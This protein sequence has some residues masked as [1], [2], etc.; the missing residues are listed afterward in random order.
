MRR[1][2]IAALG[3]FLL[4]SG[5]SDPAST[6]EGK[7][8]DATIGSVVIVDDQG[9]ETVISI[10]DADPTK[11]E[12]VLLGDVVKVTYYPVELEDG[13][14]TNEVESLRVV[15]P[16]YYRLIA[17]TWTTDGINEADRFGF[18]LAE[19]G[20]AASVNLNTLRITDWV[21]DGEQLALS[22]VPEGGDPKNP[23]TVV[24]SIEKL[25]ADSLVLRNVADGSK[26]WSCARAK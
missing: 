10:L 24:Y 21:L 26:E 7:V 13:T 9:L 4:L 18:T 11:V 17:G 20:S 1:T 6:V 8:T 12:G 2:A 14:V 16:S 23:V 5:C 22:S 3:L 15:S 25:D 19:D